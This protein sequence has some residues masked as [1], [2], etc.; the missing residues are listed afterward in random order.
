[1]EAEINIYNVI[2]NGN[3]V[4][5][6]YD[7]T[8]T[9]DALNEQKQLDINLSEIKDNISADQT[10]I[11]NK[12]IYNYYDEG[13]EIYVLLTYHIQNIKAERDVGGTNTTELFTIL[14]KFTKFNYSIVTNETIQFYKDKE[15]V[16]NIEL[17]DLTVL[18]IKLNY[19]QD[20][21][22]L[23]DNTEPGDNPDEQPQTLQIV[24]S[25]VEVG[26]KKPDNITSVGDD[27]TNTYYIVKFVEQEAPIPEYNTDNDGKDGDFAREKLEPTTVRIIRPSDSYMPDTSKPPTDNNKPNNPTSD[28][29][30]PEYDTT[31]YNNYINPK[32]FEINKLYKKVIY[33][34]IMVKSSK[35]IRKYKSNIIKYDNVEYTKN[36]LYNHIEYFISKMNNENVYKSLISIVGSL[37]GDKKNKLKKLFSDNGLNPNYYS[38][39]NDYSLKSKLELF[40]SYGHFYIDRW[41]YYREYTALKYFYKQN[42]NNTKG[43][44]PLKE[45]IDLMCTNYAQIVIYSH[46][47][48]IYD[49]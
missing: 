1:M 23:E 2:V 10:Q 33:S 14:Y 30:I 41:N 38:D 16:E 45:V 49:L 19:I 46:T 25:S 31:T 28:E 29:T 37:N 34:N 27:N 39:Y 21:N 12:T 7:I 11:D 20:N 3:I 35:E 13:Y 26:V 5:L 9:E 8:I 4:Y 24:F 15:K 48:S 6:Y 17:S 44:N 43:I 40:D 47:K 32:S 36:S 42:K 18:N 22:S